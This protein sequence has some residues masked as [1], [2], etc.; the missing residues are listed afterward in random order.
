ME[1]LCCVV[2]ILIPLI[3]ALTLNLRHE[4]VPLNLDYFHEEFID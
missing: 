3:L 2:L 4:H 1:K